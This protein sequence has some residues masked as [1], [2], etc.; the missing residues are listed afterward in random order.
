[1]FSKISRYRK[2]SDDV[3][4]D[5]RGRKLVWKSL[6]LLPEVSGTF[7]HTIEDVDRL[8]HLAFKYYTQPPNWWRICDANPEFLSPQVLLGKE[9]LVTCRFPISFPMGLN[10]PPWAGLLS[11]LRGIIGVEEVQLELETE[12][13]SETREIE[14]EERIFTTEQLRYAVVITYNRMNTGAAEFNEIMSNSGF[15]VSEP[16]T[17]GRVGKK[18]IIPPAVVG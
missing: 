16:E 9:P 2:L 11:L 13:V 6:R 14:G 18:I 17:V 8:D 4:I 1:M 10:N 12:L 3:A 15:E 5:F 7:Q